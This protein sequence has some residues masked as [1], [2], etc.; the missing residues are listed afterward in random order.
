MLSYPINTHEQAT[1]QLARGVIAQDT[2]KGRLNYPAG[3]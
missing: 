3:E 1:L 2:E